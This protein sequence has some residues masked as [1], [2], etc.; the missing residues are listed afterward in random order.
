MFNSIWKL[1]VRKSTSTY[2][3]KRKTL[4]TNHF[5]PRAAGQPHRGCRDE[6]TWPSSPCVGR[7]CKPSS[8][9]L[10]E[11]D[12]NQPVSTDSVKQRTSFIKTPVYSCPPAAGWS[13]GPVGHASRQ[14][15]GLVGTVLPVSLPPSL[16]LP[17]NFTATLKERVIVIKKAKE[18]R[19]GDFCS[20]LFASPAEPLAVLGQSPAAGISSTHTE[21]A[22]DYLPRWSGQ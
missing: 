11:Q 14:C 18:S 2:K 16:L 7:T 4:C 9:S 5:V 17:S 21:L 13:P 20:E 8:S 6:R 3:S 22:A 1:A 12:V 19:I 10:R 15:C